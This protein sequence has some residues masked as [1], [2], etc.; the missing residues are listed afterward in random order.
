[1]N[2]QPD[3]DHWTLMTTHSALT[4]RWTFIAWTRPQG[5]QE[6]PDRAISRSA[7]FKCACVRSN[8]PAQ[9]DENWSAKT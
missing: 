7:A 1:M 2:R 9:V 5:Q 6:E 3:P 8:P 4:D